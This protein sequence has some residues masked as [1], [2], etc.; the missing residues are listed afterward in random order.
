MGYILVGLQITKKKSLIEF[1]SVLGGA[2][3]DGHD[4]LLFI[5]KFHHT[6]QVSIRRKF[7]KTIYRF[8]H[9]VMPKTTCIIKIGPSLA[10]SCTC[11]YFHNAHCLG[12][13][14]THVT[15]NV[16]ILPLFI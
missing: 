7:S 13:Y 16:E 4:S 8:L 11:P 10:S 2:L 3:Q 6:Q 9:Y 14:P 5:Y 12:C 1:C 15:L